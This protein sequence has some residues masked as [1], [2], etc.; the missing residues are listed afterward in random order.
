S[1]RI[2]LQ[3]EWLN[4]TALSPVG[5]QD[6]FTQ[7]LT[8]SESGL[9]TSLYLSKLSK[10]SILLSKVLKAEYPV[11]RSSQSGVTGFQKLSKRSIQ[12]QKL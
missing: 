8:F 12:F 11:F 1:L 5:S 2:D 9:K 10:R 3:Q 4:K 6:H 7:G